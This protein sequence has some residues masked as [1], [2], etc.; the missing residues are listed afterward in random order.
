MMADRTFVLVT[1]Y[2]IF[3]AGEKDRE[4]YLRILSNLPD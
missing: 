1:D 4:E 2:D 3:K